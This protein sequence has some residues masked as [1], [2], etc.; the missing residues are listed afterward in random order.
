[1]FDN[2][3]FEDEYDL[4]IFEL[5]QTENISEC[6]ESE[7]IDN[8]LFDDTSDL[9]NPIIAKIPTRAGD[10]T[11][12]AKIPT[13]ADS[14]NLSNIESIIS[15]NL[16]TAKIPDRAGDLPTVAT[17]PFRADSY[18]PSNI[19]LTTDI[20]SNPNQCDFLSDVETDKLGCKNSETARLQKN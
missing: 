14:Y 5:Q 4:K 17:I 7:N 16:D 12:V 13:R 3:T 19:L 9:E 2:Q 15:F 8:L 20:N 6:S 1:M 11:A 10:L 18:N